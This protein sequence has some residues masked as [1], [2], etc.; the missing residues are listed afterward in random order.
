VAEPPPTVT[1][2]ST[3]VSG[4]D[5]R[6]LV[7]D[8][9]LRKLSAAFL[10]DPYPTYRALR[11]SDAVHRLPDGSYFLSRYDDCLAVYRDAETWRSDKKR[12]I[13]AP[14]SATASSTSTTP[15]ASS[16]TIRPITPACASSWRRRSH[17]GHCA[18]CRPRDR[19]AG[20]AAP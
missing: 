9:D 3:P 13:S 16:S 11:E 8:F 6:A 14:I 4:D 19:G 5:L 2:I 12:S 18:R 20:R 17:R 1:T 7:A 10:D 15:R